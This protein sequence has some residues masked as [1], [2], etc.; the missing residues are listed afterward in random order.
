MIHVLRECK[1]GTT[2]KIAMA[3]SRMRRVLC[4]TWLGGCGAYSPDFR[5]V[6]AAVYAWNHGDVKVRKR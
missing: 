6:E 1:C 4:P 5:T 2:P 3:E